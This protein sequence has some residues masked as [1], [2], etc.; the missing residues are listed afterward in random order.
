M[1][2]FLSILP[3]LTFLTGTLS[4]ITG[5]ILFMNWQIALIFGGAVLILVANY[6][7]EIMSVEVEEQ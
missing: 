6:L 4:V 7:N 5:M 2:L 3:E 1:K